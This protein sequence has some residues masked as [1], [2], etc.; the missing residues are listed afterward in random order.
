MRRYLLKVNGQRHCPGGINRPQ[1]DADWEGGSIELPIEGPELAGRGARI[2]APDIS[3]GDEL[4]IWCHENRE[5]GNGLGLTARAVAGQTIETEGRPHVCLVDVQIFDRKVGKA[6]YQASMVPS[7]VIDY[8]MVRTHHKA[9]LLEE[10]DHEELLAVVAERDR[11]FLEYQVREQEGFWDNAI[12]AREQGNEPVAERRRRM[13]FD[14]PEQAR[15]RREVFA[16][17]GKTACLL[18]G[19]KIEAAIEAAHVVPHNGHE[20]WDRPENGIPLRAD[21]HGMFDAGLWGIDPE[22]S[23]VVFS[24]AL[25]QMLEECD[26]LRP[27]EGDKIAHL[28][29][30]PLLSWHISN[31]MGEAGRS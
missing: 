18:T 28:V 17:Y 25:L 21:L 2:D 24:E 4:W 19:C 20:T 23:K 8:L 29:P 10:R 7:R 16:R 5:F 14:R 27:L 13:T 31:R 1:S 30:K 11:P 15:F 3:P 26:P 6:V 12:A 9:Y 22:T